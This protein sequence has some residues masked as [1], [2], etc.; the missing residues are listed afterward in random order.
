MQIVPNVYRIKNPISN[1]YLIVEDDG[2][3]LID[4]GVSSAYGG[5]SAFTQSICKAPQDLIRILLTHADVDHVSTAM[6][7]KQ[8]SGAKIFASRI[9]AEALAEGHSSRRLPMGILT[10]LADWFE[11]RGGQM[12]VE[13]DQILSE[14]DMLPVLGG[15][16][17][18]ETPGHTPCHISFYI[19][20]QKMLFAGDAV[21]TRKDHVGYNW[22]RVSN[23]DHDVMRQS[24]HK[25]A[26]LQPEVVCP[27]HG[28]VVFGAATKDRTEYYLWTFQGVREIKKAQS[29]TKE[30]F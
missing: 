8:E 30:I 24:V 14:G 29:Q 10:P 23:W 13:V 4:A 16:K 2:L 5:I 28:P 7:L 21:R 27:G 1:C 26:K 6:A 22:L 3:T 19:K 17:V 12:E 18:V 20:S 11:A 9:A 25:L 15:L